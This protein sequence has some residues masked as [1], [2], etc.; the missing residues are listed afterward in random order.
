MPTLG[1]TMIYI[2]FGEMGIGKNYVGEKLAARLGCKFFDGDLVVPAPMAEKVTN[3]KPLTPE[4]I[5]D[6]VYNHLISGIEKELSRETD[7]V[8]AQALYLKTHRDAIR[9]H[10]GK[11]NIKF[12]YLPVPSVFTHMSRLWSRENG[13]KW[14]LFGLFNKFFFEKPSKDVAVIINK[15]GG[16]LDSQ[17][18][19]L[20]P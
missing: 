2:L 12:V 8:V 1:N 19:N 10:F 6:F 16:D 11:E 18:K 20:L 7:L 4:D 13:S 17:I 14:M 3:F 5:D 15:T 9:K